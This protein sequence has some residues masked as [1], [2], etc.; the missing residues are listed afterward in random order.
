MNDKVDREK[1][2]EEL[3][4]LQRRML[5]ATRQHRPEVWMGIDLTISQFKSLMFIDCEGGTNSK[6]LAVALGV[7]P[8][9]VTGIIDRL[10]EQKLVCRQENPED[11]RVAILTVTEQ[12]KALLGR[13]GERRTSIVASILAGL[14]IDELSSLYHGLTA[15]LREVEIEQQHNSVEQTR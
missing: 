3:L 9:N 14:S 8:P 2:T 6:K 13:L 7:T 15:L 4:L 11:R 10:V 5:N 12:G 1:L